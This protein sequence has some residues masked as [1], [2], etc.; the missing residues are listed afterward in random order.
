MSE[1]QPNP[2]RSF[3]QERKETAGTVSEQVRR[4][5]AG[6]H[7]VSLEHV[8][9]VEAE[10]DGEYSG[11][12]PNSLQLLDY[13]GADYL[14]RDGGVTA[15]VAARVRP[16]EEEWR[17]M[18]LRTDNGTT[19]PSEWVTIPKSI[20]HGG[21]YPREYL[22]GI[23]DGDTLHRAAVWDTADLFRAA[24]DGDVAVSDEQQ[25]DDGSAYVRIPVADL[26]REHI[27]RSVWFRSE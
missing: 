7:G 26:F 23:R 6:S 15:P 5:L 16:G 22:L 18:T 24:K 9:N 19:A 11:G 13:S 20:R 27:H 3:E 10:S 25:N 21:I 12:R 1:S 4:V 17:D 8:H 2:A 14:I